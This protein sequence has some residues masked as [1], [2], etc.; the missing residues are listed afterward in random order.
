MDIFYRLFPVMNFTLTS[1][2]VNVDFISTRAY[3][4]QGKRIQ[5][6]NMVSLILMLI[7]AIIQSV[8]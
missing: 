1:M 5:V 6:P 3:I 4:S 7:L 8:I 2:V